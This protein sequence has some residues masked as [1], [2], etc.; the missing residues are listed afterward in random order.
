MKHNNTHIT[1]IPEGG[2]SEQEIKNL[3]EEIMTK[4]F[5]NLVK[6]KDTP[7]QEVQRV[8]NKLDPKK[9]TPRHIII[10]MTGLK[11]LE[12]ILNATREKQVITYKGALIKLSSD[13][14][15]EIFQN[16]SSMKYSR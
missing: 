9:T 5:L 11:N 10:K 3:F 7:I 4:D 1:G 8:P 13:F 16:R 12:R 15:T 2:E 6:G 14:S